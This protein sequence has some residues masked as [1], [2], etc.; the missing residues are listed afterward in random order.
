MLVNCVAYQDGKR[1]AEI[2]PREIHQYLRRPGG[3]VSNPR[4]PGRAIRNAVVVGLRTTV[5]Y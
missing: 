4:D 3:H 2:S 1:L 5:Q